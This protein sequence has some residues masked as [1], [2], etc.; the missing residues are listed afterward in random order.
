[1]TGMYV[2]T[3][4]KLETLKD[5]FTDNLELS[6]ILTKLLSVV[7]NQYQLRQERYARDLRDFEER[8]GMD[9]LAFH[10]RFDVG[11]LGDSADFFE[12]DG[13]YDL[14]RDLAE[15][16]HRLEAAL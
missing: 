5:T 12:W 8:Y 6:H 7:I 9:T 16:I 11:E 1:M 2:D 14:Q 4:H 13:L 10:K 3:F 15:K